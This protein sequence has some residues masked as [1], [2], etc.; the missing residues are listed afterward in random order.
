MKA[1]IVDDCSMTREM[2][3][4]CIN[5]VF[6]VDYAENGEEAV[7]RVRDAIRAGECYDLICMD[8]TMPV[9]GGQEALQAIRS[10]EAGDGGKR[11][12]V[13]MITASSSPEDMIEAIT[14][15]DC[16]DYLTK[17][18]IPHAFKELLRKHSLIS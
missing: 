4:L 7:S 12:T 10:L 6:H 16:D 1:L 17:P 2:V 18:V 13:F 3:G 8:I 14:G 5:N 11:S 15:G 9:M